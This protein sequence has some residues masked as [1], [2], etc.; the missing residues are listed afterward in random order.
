MNLRGRVLRYQ[1][2]PYT[3]LASTLQIRSFKERI[4]L[5]L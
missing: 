1:T 3:S 2:V 4:R 5:E